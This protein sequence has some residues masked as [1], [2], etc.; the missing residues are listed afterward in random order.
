[1][2]SSRLQFTIELVKY[3]MESDLDEST[4]HPFVKRLT[5]L[6]DREQSW[7][8]ITWKRHHRLGL[9]SVASIYEF[10]GG[11]YGNG[12]EHGKREPIP[13]ISFFELPFSGCD[14]GEEYRMWTHAFE[15]IRILDFTIDPSQDLLV[16]VTRAPAESKFVFEVHLR[17]LSANDPYPRAAAPILPCFPKDLVSMPLSNSIG[18]IRVQISG[19]LIGFLMKE[20]D[21]IEVWHPASGFCSSFVLPSG[22]DDFT[23]LSQTSFLIVRPLGYLEVYQF[24]TPTGSSP[25]PVL[26]GSFSFP[27]LSDGFSFWHCSL[28]GN[29]SPG[30]IP[31]SQPGVNS[32]VINSVYHPSLADRVLACCI[33]ILEPSPDPARHRVHSFVFF[34]HVNLFLQE[35]PH[36]ILGLCKKSEPPGISDQTTDT[37]FFSSYST[38]SLDASRPHNPTPTNMSPVEWDAWG[39]ANTRWF[40][41]CLTT[42]WQHALHGM[43][44]AESISIKVYDGMSKAT[45]ETLEEMAEDEDE[46]DNGVCNIEEDVVDDSEVAEVN[47]HEDPIDAKRY[48]A[49]IEVPSGPG[50]SAVPMHRYLR[51]RD[52]NPFVVRKGKGLWDESENPRWR[53]RRVI[54]Q[55]TIT[56][57]EGAFKKNIESSL[58]YT[59]VLRGSNIG[60]LAAGKSDI[61]TQLIRCRLWLVTVERDGVPQLHGHFFSDVV[62]KVGEV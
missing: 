47:Y 4:S 23:F 1:M 49:D 14:P 44:T 39:P 56:Q 42:D 50:D 31:R 41:E 32:N 22:I 61:E 57:V 8:S 37:F 43:R 10:V 18:A 17:T 25:P 16:L 12:R 6:R 38:K 62:N 59:E 20:M 26:L 24:H 58:P 3:R 40:R 54:T 55:P 19:D 27:P 2:Q 36:S 51:I 28:S 35:N 45:M 52:F 11:I 48:G 46:D 34:F 21:T 33:Y 7:R 53:R 15:N 9:P 5:S 60:T 13:A 29:P 30:Y